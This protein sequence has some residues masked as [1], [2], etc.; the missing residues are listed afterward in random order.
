MEIT[1]NVDMNGWGKVKKAAMITVHK[2]MKTLP[3]HEWKMEILKSEHSPIREMGVSVLFEGIPRHVAD[4][5]VRHHVGVN[6]YMG[7]WRPDRGNKAR[8]DQRMTDET[9]LVLSMNLQAILNISRD[10]LCMG[11]ES[12]TRRVWK[13]FLDKLKE[14]EP[15][16][17]FFCVP[18]CVR[19]LACKEFQSCGMIDKFFYGKGHEKPIT[20]IVGRY[21]DFHKWGKDDLDIKENLGSDKTGHDNKG[22]GMDK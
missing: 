12:E 13:A 5:L 9:N 6:C 7:T 16:I 17:A 19:L 1:I 20:D 2:K 18:S 14:E 11:V 8:E 21:D 4:Q 3:D 22:S 15:E 10:R